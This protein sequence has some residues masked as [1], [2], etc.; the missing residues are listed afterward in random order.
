MIFGGVFA[1][2]SVGALV[3]GLGI[4]GFVAAVNLERWRMHRRGEDVR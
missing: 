1:V 3:W 2:V 4:L